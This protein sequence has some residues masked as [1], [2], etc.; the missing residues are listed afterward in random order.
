MAASFKSDDSFLRK[1]VVG[2]A[3]TNATIDRLTALGFR[4][5]ELERGSTGFKIWKKIKIKRVR[6]PDILC[7]RTGLRFESRGKTKPEISMSHSLSETRRAWDAGMRDDDFISIV[8]FHQ[9]AESPI[10]LKPIS[11]V[12]FIKVKDLRD[13]FGGNRVSITKPKGV[14]EGS[15]IRV[16][17]MSAVAAQPSI[18]SEISEKR[19]QLKDNESGRIQTVQ[20]VRNKGTITL[21]PQVCVGDT[22][23]AN[24]IVAASVPVSVALSCPPPVDEAYFVD[25][26]GNTN[27]SERYAAAKALRYRGYTTARRALADRMALPDEDIYVQLEAAAALAAHGHPEGWGFMEGKLRSDVMHVPLETQLETVIVVSEIPDPSSESLLIEVLKDEGRD[28]ELRAGAAWALGQFATPAAANALVATFN[29][30]ELG[31]KTEAARSLLKITGKQVDP[32]V[33]LLKTC[34]PDQ[35]DGLSWALA[36]SG[37]FDPNILFDG[38]DDNLRRWI[39]Y[40]LGHGKNLFSTRDVEAVCTSDPQVYFAASVLWQILESWIDGLTEV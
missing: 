10:D 32:V 33:E 40:I 31:V 26:L 25:K 29:S 6:V 18:V 23:E 3:G 24:R 39:S 8:V 35:R 27:L 20:L 22:V 1:L 34:M 2:A 17:W 5:I 30:A 13:A 14:E 19:I 36:R 21:E 28:D 12:Q 11:P 38:A 16:V 7:L 15:E 37:G 4:P 9:S